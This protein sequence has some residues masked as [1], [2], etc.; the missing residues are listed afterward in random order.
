[1]KSLPVGLRAYLSALVVM[2]VVGVVAACGG[3]GGAADEAATGEAA[4]ADQPVEG[5]LTFWL[6]PDVPAIQDFWESLIADFE[7]QHPNANVEFTPLDTDVQ[8]TKPAAAFAAGDEPDIL[9]RVAGED[10]NQY[11]RAGKIAPINDLVD[12]TSW[13]EAALALFSDADGNVYGAPTHSFVLGLWYNKQVFSENGLEIPTSWDGLL[14]ACD[15]L[16]AAGVVPIALGNGGQDQFTAG[17]LLDAILYQYGGPTI[18]LDA[19]FGENGRTWED[20]AVVKAA[21]RLKELVDRN[22]FPNGFSGLNYSQMTALFIRGESGMVWTGSWLLAP[23]KDEGRGIEVGFIPLPDVPDAEHSTV[24]LEGIIGGATGLAA[25]KKGVE[26]DSALVAAFLD[27][28]G[29]ATDRYATE[30]NQVSVASEPATPGD[31]VQAEIVE[32]ASSAGELAPVTDTVVPVSVRDAYFQS[33]QALTTGDLTPEEFAKA[34]AE[35]A[36]EA[37]S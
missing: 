11:V 8:L 25:T 27:A 5:T 30:L 1:M 12:L 22:C 19:T 29:E 17:H 20:P 26:K 9:Q 36:A 7:A 33:T 6:T 32:L 16:N 13:S 31:P 2:L 3:G 15:T 21:S 24:E 28:V 4:A 18:A 34:M 37:S 14:A 35:A 23:I 10:L